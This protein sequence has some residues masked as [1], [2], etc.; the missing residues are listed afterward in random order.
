MTMMRLA[1]NK[2]FKESKL[3]TTSTLSG[4]LTEV[5]VAPKLIRPT[6]YPI[7]LRVNSQTPFSL[8]KSDRATFVFEAESAIFIPA[9]KMCQSKQKCDASL[10]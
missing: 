3:K 8:S 9:I 1:K 4:Y 5:T 7:R 6:L 2:P 10:L